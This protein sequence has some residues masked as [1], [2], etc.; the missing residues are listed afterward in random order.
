MQQKPYVLV[1]E[2]AQDIA[3]IYAEILEMEGV[4]VEIVMDGTVALQRLKTA[5]PDLI[6][7]DMHLPNVS[8]LEILAFIRNNPQLK[9]TRVIVIIANPY[10]AQ[11]AESTADMT[12][13]KP[14]S[15]IQIREISMRMLNY[16][17]S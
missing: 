4:S 3:E 11:D 16:L 13:V 5:M 2:D 14:V 1:I 7:L 8:G 6:L 17:T 9:R 10:L 12:L 15:A